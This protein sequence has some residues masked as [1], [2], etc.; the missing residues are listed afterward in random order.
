MVRTHLLGNRGKDKN[1]LVRQAEFRKL[2]RIQRNGQNHNPEITSKSH[3][4][5]IVQSVKQTKCGLGWNT[6]WANRGRDTSMIRR[7]Q[8]HGGNKD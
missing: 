5:K 6:E 8:G 2:H 4:Q 3:L 7:K 1:S